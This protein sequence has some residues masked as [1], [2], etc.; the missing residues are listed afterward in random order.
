MIVQEGHVEKLEYGWWEQ[1]RGNIMLPKTLG[2]PKN[3]VLTPEEL[4]HY[5]VYLTQ[6]AEKVEHE[7]ARVARTIRAF[8]YGRTPI[9][10][11]ADPTCFTLSHVMEFLLVHTK[12]K[13]DL[14]HILNYIAKRRVD[15]QRSNAE[16]HEGPLGADP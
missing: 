2:H 1:K 13:L 14:L 10:E 5:D 3:F 9:W 8:R 6:F 11:Q 4:A 12:G 15:E 7:R 16:A